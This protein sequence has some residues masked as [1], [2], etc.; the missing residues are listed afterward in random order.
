MEKETEEAG[1]GGVER[2]KRW[3]EIKGSG[4]GNIVRPLPC[5]S[6][7]LPGMK[8]AQRNVCSSSG[9]GEKRRNSSAFPMIRV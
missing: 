7:I 9:I 5:I 1:T 8:I 3:G 2:V 4:T 6:K